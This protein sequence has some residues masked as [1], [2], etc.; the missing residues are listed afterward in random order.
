MASVGLVA[1]EGATASAKR[2]VLRLKWEGCGC[3]CEAFR[4]KSERLSYWTNLMITC[5]QPFRHH[6]F[7]CLR[8]TCLQVFAEL[9]D[10]ESRRIV[11]ELAAAV[12]RDEKPAA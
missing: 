8:V 1:P 9:A 12:L 10:V 11:N 6:G 2:Q 3:G 7:A 4:R 5:L